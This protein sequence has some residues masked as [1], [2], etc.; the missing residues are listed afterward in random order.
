MS[1]EIEMTHR[2]INHSPDDK[3][4]EFMA[5]VTLYCSQFKL[6]CAQCTGSQA[7][8]NPSSRFAFLITWVDSRNLGTAD[9]VRLYQLIYPVRDA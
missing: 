5:C 4:R 6:A 1:S 3:N 7:S 2:V 9:I 8:L